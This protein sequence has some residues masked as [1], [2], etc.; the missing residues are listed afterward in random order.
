MKK[1]LTS[2]AVVLV[3]IFALSPMAFAASADQ[4]FEKCKSEAEADEVGDSDIKIYVTNCMKDL[5]ADADETQAMV[6][7]EYSAPEQG[8]AKSSAD[9]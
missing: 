9:E 5:G 2:G 6:D 8:T 7:A 1:L 3:I 4:A